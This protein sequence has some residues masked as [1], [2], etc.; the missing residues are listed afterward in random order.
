MYVVFP[1]CGGVY[2][3]DTG[4]I[5]SPN[6]PSNYPVNKICRYSIRGRIGAVVRVNFFDFRMEDSSFGPCT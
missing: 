2:T 4:F 5:V 3:S 1:G 6:Y